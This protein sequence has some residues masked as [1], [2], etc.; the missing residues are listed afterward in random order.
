[1]YIHKRG[2]EMRDSKI[3]KSFRRTCVIDVTMRDALCDNFDW[4]MEHGSTW[5]TWVRAESCLFFV[6]SVKIFGLRLLFVPIL[7]SF[8]S[9]A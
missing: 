2:S 8:F 1:M 5:S 6:L 3:R 9:I 4:L 7:P